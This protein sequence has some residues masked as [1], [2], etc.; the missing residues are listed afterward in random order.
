MSDVWLVWVG[1][2]A[3]A[4]AAAV[5]L[6]FLVSPSHAVPKARR[7]YRPDQTSG[8]LTRAADQATAT[9]GRLL[10]ER[11][12][13]LAE[14]LVRAGVKQRPRDVLVLTAS[15]VLALFAVGLLTRGPLLALVLALTAPLGVWLVL[16]VRTQRRQRA[17]AE[18]L[19]ETLGMLA[20]SLR[21]GYSLPQAAATVA[22]EAEAP[23]SEEFARVINE[24]R[25]G[26]SLIDAFHDAAVRVRSDDFFWIV[27]AIAINREV[28][29]NLAD[30]LDGVGRTIRERVHLRRQVD[31]LASEGKLSAII[32][33]ALPP[34]VILMLSVVNPGYIAKFGESP[35]GILLLVGAAVLLVVGALWLRVLVRIKF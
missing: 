28:G 12:G 27:Q 7:R 31:S 25:V 4:F 18:Q 14:A 3:L 16:V 22:T 30:V 8:V 17:F 9:A 1:G 15:A 24:A 29:G 10:G 33:I 21:A 11:E 35:V 2:A 23:T 34:V 26:R 5:A 13:R 32:L 6:Y 19:E 20:G